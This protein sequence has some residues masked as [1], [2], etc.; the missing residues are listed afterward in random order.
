VVIGLVACA[1]TAAGLHLGR[2]IG[3]VAGRR[4]EI[5]GGA[6]LVGISVKI[7]VGHL[8]G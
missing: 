1:L 3:E 8:S 5:A 6:I 7:L 2:R 4:M